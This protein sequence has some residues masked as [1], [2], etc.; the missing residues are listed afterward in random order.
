[1][2]SSD[3]NST[4][5]AQSLSDP[6]PSSHRNSQTL[7]IP[8]HLVFVPDE[9]DI[10]IGSDADADNSLR[11]S[12]AQRGQWT[13]IL[14]RTKGQIYALVAGARR[15]RAAKRLSWP[16]IR[17]TILPD[18]A[19][20]AGEIT[21]LENLERLQ[22]TPVEEA[23][24]LG[25]LLQRP[26]NTVEKLTTALR[27]SA[28][29]ITGRIEM[30]S[31]PPDLLKHIHARTISLGAARE[32]AAVASQDERARLIHH[33]AEHGITTATARLWRQQADTYAA[34]VAQTPAGATLPAV[35]E[36][37]FVPHYRCAFCQREHPTDQ[38]TTLHSCGPC[39]E[40]LQEATQKA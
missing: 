34:D 23:N 38:C 33:A 39:L 8:L 30:L 12:M 2:D 32:L 10:R 29:W 27:R 28:E 19:G 7:D 17:A 22:L 35:P 18:T 9:Q 36:L 20:A 21:L 37:R 4:Q 24:A 40:Q 3:W 15:L 13:P 6:S 31:Y 25:E 14:V 5:T 11:D 1:V 16:T 26:E